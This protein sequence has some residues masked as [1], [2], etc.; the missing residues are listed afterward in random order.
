M[1]KGGPENLENTPFPSLGKMKFT[2]FTNPLPKQWQLPRRGL[3]KVLPVNCAGHS[4]DAIF[5][6]H[7]QHWVVFLVRSYVWVTNAPASNLSSMLWMQAQQT[8]WLNKLNFNGIVSSICCWNPILSDQMS[9]HISSE[10]VT[11]QRQKPHV[12]A[13]LLITEES[14]P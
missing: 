7:Q 1:E 5:V 11:R 2:G 14:P 12:Q 8:H 9:V 13:D 3:T 4:R 10:K 6:S